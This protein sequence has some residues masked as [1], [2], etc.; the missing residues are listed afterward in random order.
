MASKKTDWM[1]V[2]A[3][4]GDKLGAG[5]IAIANFNASEPGDMI[6]GVPQGRSLNNS[7][8]DAGEVRIVYGVKR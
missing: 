4:P 1:A 8:I 6:L 7:R 2:G 5:G 3:D